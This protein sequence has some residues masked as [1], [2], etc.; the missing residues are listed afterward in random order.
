MRYRKSEGA[1]GF[2]SLSRSIYV[3]NGILI[4]VGGGLEEE[5]ENVENGENG[6]RFGL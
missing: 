2:A 1:S 5:K 3:S 6:S 4:V